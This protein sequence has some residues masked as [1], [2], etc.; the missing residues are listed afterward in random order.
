V[1]G[2]LA[3]GA[4]LGSA[5]AEAQ[6]IWSGRVRARALVA[7]AESLE[8]LVA[9]QDSL[10]K[11][12]RYDDLRARR[13]DAGNLTVLLPGVVGE[14]IGRRIAAR[15]RSYLDSL[16]AIPPGFLVSRVVIAYLATG[17]DSVLRAHGL[18]GRARIMV[19]I[20]VAPDS[21]AHGWVVAAAVT[22]A[23][24][25]TLDP[26][27]RA[28]L[29][30]DLGLGFMRGRDDAAAVR[31][32]AAGDTRVGTG[33]LGGEPAACRLWLGLDHD[34]DPYSARYTPA[35]IR[36]IVGRRMVEYLG[37]T[38]QQ[39]VHGSDDAC[40]R[41]ARSGGVSPVPSGLA[42]VRSVLRA[43]LILHGAEALRHALADTSGA[44]GQRLSR[45]AGIG[46]DSLVSEWRAWLLTG[47]G[48]PRVS[49]SAGDALPVLLF[50]GLLL[51]AA[52]RSG[53]WR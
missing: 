17:R 39:C 51:F 48:R 46:E 1:A 11:Q 8:T 35:E 31:E 41:Y 49:A 43:I 10:A 19:D 29:P 38:V 13:F 27:W 23:Y 7:R 45:A 32:L 22:R 47:G 16:G 28:W 34:A 37:A 14:D 9:R 2:A 52:A 44:I 12:R 5:T 24:V 42:S 15:A 4:V 20:P 6:G 40:L 36:V 30:M 50:G 25:E 33:C 26:G 53:R 21:A 18:G 3:L